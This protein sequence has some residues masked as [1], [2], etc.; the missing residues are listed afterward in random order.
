MM[1]QS[2]SRQ[3]KVHVPHKSFVEKLKAHL[4]TFGPGLITGASDDDPSGIGTYAQTGALFGYAQLWMAL[5]TFPLSAAIQEICARIAMQTGT[6]LTENIRKHYP[7]PVL[8]GCVFLLVVA[9]TIN[10][11]ADLGAMAVSAQLLLGIPYWV[12]LTGITLLIIG[13]EV[14]IDYKYYA[15]VLRFFTLSL[16]A[17]ILAAFVIAQ[18]W[19][20][21]VRN[22]LLPTFQLSQDYFLNL[23]A[24]LGTTISPYLFFWQASQEVEEEIDEGRKSRKARQGVSKGELK[25]MRTDVI[26]GMFFSNL[27]TW[28]III[29][30]ASTL[31][32]NGVHNIDSAPTAAQALRPV[33]GNLAYAL[34]AAGIIGTGL[35]A[36]PVLAGSAA[37]AVAETFRL[38]E[39]L[40]LK[41]R[42]AHGFYAVIAI[43]TLVGAAI[44]L[45]GI[46]PLQA[47]YFTAVING[48]VAPPLLIM[49][50]L[51]SRNRKIMGN[52][53]NGRLSDFLGWLVTIVMTL[54]AGALLLALIS[55]H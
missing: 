21:V 54:A 11:G 51:I 25:W 40:Y 18:D 45:L 6:G 46:N 53:V 41:L 38:R 52:K 42:Q 37:Y 30:T 39:G 31:Y 47:L 2:K 10:V 23:V 27:V 26:S 28:C 20:Q 14:F 49:I 24:V 55:R 22:T 15:Q 12:W 16:F 4:K 29:T 8:Y 7:R 44:N 17:Y 48:V 34:F 5:Y 43:S 32:N 35:L 9:N 36:V 1:A 19:G 13:L 50:M 3:V 33:A